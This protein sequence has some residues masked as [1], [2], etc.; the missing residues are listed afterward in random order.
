[1]VTVGSSRKI[2]GVDVTLPTI[3]YMDGVGNYINLTENR[4]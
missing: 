3:L 2:I 1:M 4:N